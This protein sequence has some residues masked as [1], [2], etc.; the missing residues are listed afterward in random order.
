MK[1][2]LCFPGST[3]LKIKNINTTNLCIHTLRG[4]CSLG[5]RIIDMA[6]AVPAIVILNERKAFILFLNQILHL[7]G[8]DH[9]KI[10]KVYSAGT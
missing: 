9:I 1:V 6:V 7:L 2:F 3:R 8:V 5:F 4:L 10:L